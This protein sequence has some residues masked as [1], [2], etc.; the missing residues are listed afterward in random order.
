[1]G[2]FKNGLKHG[3]GKWRSAKGPQSNTYEGDYTNDKK[4]GYGIFN[5]ASG[6]TY[7]G[8]YKEDERDGYGEMRWTDGSI[9]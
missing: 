6:N 5:W 7:K 2:E 1:M 3:K 9:Y 8:E 4:H